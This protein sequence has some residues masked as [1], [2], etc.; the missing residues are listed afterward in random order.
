MLLEG[1]VHVA[2]SRAHKKGFGMYLP[3]DLIILRL[4]PEKASKQPHAAKMR[5]LK[6]FIE[7]N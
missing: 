3:F 2:S 6:A 4:Y 1:Q 7:V 5:H